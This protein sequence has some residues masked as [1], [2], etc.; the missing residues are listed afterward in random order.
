MHVFVQT[1]EAAKNEVV[2]YRRHDDGSL[3]ELGR[4]AT[5]GRGDGLPHLK[6]QGSVVLEGDRLFVANAGSNDVSVFAV[7]DDRVELIAREPSG[8]EAPTSIAVRGDAV[9]VLN[10]AATPNVT[11]F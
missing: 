3:V 1:N 10:A 8:G 11:G 7:A 2:A 6:S 5:G 4:Y 9:Y